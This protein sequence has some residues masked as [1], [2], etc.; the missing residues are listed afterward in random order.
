MATV[1]IIAAATCIPLRLPFNHWADPPLCVGKPRTTL[2]SVL[3]RVALGNGLV[4]WGQAYGGEITAVSALMQ[5]RIAPLGCGEDAS[6]QT[7]TARLERTLHNP[8]R[9]GSCGM[10]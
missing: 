10:R 2:D 9:S 4:G 7:L 5:S 1:S 8:G 3:V 6:D